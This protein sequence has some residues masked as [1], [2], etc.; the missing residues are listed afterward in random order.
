M[1]EGL[2]V[3]QGFKVYRVSRERQALTLTPQMSL[4][5]SHKIKDSKLRSLMS[6]RRFTQSCSEAS[7]DCRENR[8]FKVYQ[9]SADLRVTWA[10]KATRSAWTL[11]KMEMGS[12]TGL[13]RWWGPL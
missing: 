2:K 10:L 4:A 3:I 12:L 7:A 9:A 11:I 8:D 6:S 5:S 1:S 13:R